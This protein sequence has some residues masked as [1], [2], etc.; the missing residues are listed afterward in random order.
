[1]L[2]FC[3]VNNLPDNSATRP[4][5]LVENKLTENKAIKLNQ[6]N[7]ATYLRAVS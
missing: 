1:M 7:L 6:F 2:L 3:D 4:A 5:V